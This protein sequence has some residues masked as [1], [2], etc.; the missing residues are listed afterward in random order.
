MYVTKGIGVFTL[1]SHTY[2][3]IK[4]GTGEGEISRSGT[5]LTEIKNNKLGLK[6]YNLFSI[7]NF[8]EK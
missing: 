2:H 8:I 6:P 3:W 7:Y 4:I 5:T 1:G